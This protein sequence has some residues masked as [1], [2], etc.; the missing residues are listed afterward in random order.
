MPENKGKERPLKRENCQRV[1]TAFITFENEEAYLFA[2]SFTEE[3]K[4][5]DDIDEKSNYINVA[6]FVE[7]SLKVEAEDIT[8][9]F[10][11][12][13]AADEE[14]EDNMHFELILTKAPE[15]TDIIWENLFITEDDR[16]WKKWKVKVNAFVIMGAV[17]FVTYKISG[18][19]VSY[20]GISDYRNCT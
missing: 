1:R 19:S 20:A 18:S 9:N 8:K 10:G 7:K 13:N 12:E 17:F 6:G 2:L 3:N 16:Y 11:K 4:K 15:P 14:L 5:Y